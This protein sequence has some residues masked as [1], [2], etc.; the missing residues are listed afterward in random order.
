LLVDSDIFFSLTDKRDTNHHK[1]ISLNSKFIGQ[2]IKF[3]TTN[4]VVFETATVLSHK[5]SHQAATTFLKE[6][7]SGAMEILHLDEMTE[8]EAINIFNKQQRRNSSFVDCANMAVL[9]KINLKYIFSFDRAYKSNGFLRA[10][11]D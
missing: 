8:K 7:T 5:I 3:F 9:K 10:G 1:A 4:L 2:K 11:I 6:I